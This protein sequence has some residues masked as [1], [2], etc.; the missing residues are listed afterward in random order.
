M[1]EVGDFPELGKK[2]I[3]KLISLLSYWKIKSWVTE[4]HRSDSPNSALS[5]YLCTNAHEHDKLSPIIENMF[6]ACPAGIYSLRNEHFERQ[7]GKDINYYFI[8]TNRGLWTA[9]GDWNFQPGEKV[10]SEGSI[11][12]EWKEKV[13]SPMKY[14]LIL[15]KPTQS[16]NG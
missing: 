2:R 4:P 8:R 1:A 15:P 5:L 9:F 11:S 14:R 6:N 16:T 13:D 10:L 7:Y 3:N 12:F